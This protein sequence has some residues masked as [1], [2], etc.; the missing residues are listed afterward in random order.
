MEEEYLLL[1]LQLIAIIVAVKLHVVENVIVFV[2]LNVIVGVQVVLVVV[3]M[4]ALR[5][6]MIVAYVLLHLTLL[7]LNDNK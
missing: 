6:V 2:I 3:Q 7:L 1:A 5:D 4:N